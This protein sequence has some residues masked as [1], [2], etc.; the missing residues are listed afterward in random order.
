[1]LSD[2]WCS[3]LTAQTQEL[4][5]S[6]KPYLRTYSDLKMPKRAFYLI[7]CFLLYFGICSQN[8]FHVVL[9]RLH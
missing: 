8:T 7:I 4:A 2:R 6:A 3:Y 5:S 9:Q 1:M